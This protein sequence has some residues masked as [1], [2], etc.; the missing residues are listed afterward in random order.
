M[1]SKKLFKTDYPGVFFILGKRAGK[2]DKEEKIFYIVY[3]RQ[4]KLINEKAGKQFKDDMTPARASE[5]RTKRMEGRELSNTQRREAARKS[6]EKENPWTM[7]KLWE[8]YE[9]TKEPGRALTNDRVRFDKYLRDHFGKKQPHEIV[10][11]DIDR[12]KRRELK[13]KKP[14]TVKHVLGLLQRLVRFGLGR[15]LCSALLFRI[16]FPKV[17]NLRTE[18]LSSNQ[19]QNLL[20]ALDASADIMTANLMRMALYTGMRRG[21]LFKL[22]WD[23]IDFER[24]FIKIRQPKGGKDET[25]PLNSAAGEVLRNHP[26]KE[27]KH[28]V[29]YREDGEAFT[30]ITRQA[31]RIMKAAG[32]PQDFRPLHGLRH[33]Y[34]SALASSGKVDLYVLQRLLTHKSPQMTQRYSHLRDQALRQASDLAGEL[35]RVIRQDAQAEE[36]TVEGAGNDY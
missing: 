10:R 36:S 25:I 35:F 2:G 19:L 1:S 31:R 30:D 22:R 9:H 21:E 17:N 6:K 26:R 28:L 23:D 14:Q 11:L 5:I 4:G 27:G 18:D 7:N 3:R 8:E 15:G 34:A 33:H 16:E 24:G 32:I 13:D 12:I 20:K 29:F